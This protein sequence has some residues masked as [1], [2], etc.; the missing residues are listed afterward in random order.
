MLCRRRDLTTFSEAKRG[1]AVAVA[2]ESLLRRQSRMLSFGFPPISTPSSIVLILGSLPGRL[3]LE[4]GQY[5]ASPRNAFWKIIAERIPDLPSD[6][7]TRVAALIAHRVALWDV[8]AA[9]TRSGSLDAAIAGDAIANNFR[10]FYNAHPN[11]KLICFNGATAARL[12][13]RHVLPTLVETQHALPRTT[14]PS[15]SSAH[16]GLSLA[17]KAERW[18]IIWR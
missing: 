14:L 16:A 10:A 15:T 17:K 7:P 13:E 3:S 18:S 1:Y 4:H 12:Y 8:L 2:F 9:A 11:I 5:Y 6:Y